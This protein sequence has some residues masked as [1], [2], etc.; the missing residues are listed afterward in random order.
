MKTR[1]NHAESTLETLAQ[2][3]LSG[4]DSHAMLRNFQR[5]DVKEAE[6]MSDALRDRLMQGATFLSDIE[7]D[8]RKRGDIALWERNDWR[9]TCDYIAARLNAGLPC[10]RVNLEAT[11]NLKED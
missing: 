7:R 10:L 5:G 11:L 6:A 9:E 2:V 3:A 8:C 4:F 1:F